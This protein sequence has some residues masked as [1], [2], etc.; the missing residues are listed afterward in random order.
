LP[1][2]PT[3]AESGFPGFESYTWVAL[4]GPANMPASIVTRINGAINDALRTNEVRANLASLGFDVKPGTPAEFG[5]YLGQEVV[6][7][8]DLVKQTGIALQ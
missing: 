5:T 7:W 6:K 3:V 2:L 8:G 4:L 1:N